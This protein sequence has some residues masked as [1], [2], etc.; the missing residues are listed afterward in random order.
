MDNEF[1][2]FMKF[3][4]QNINLTSPAIEKGYWT[5]DKLKNVSVGDENQDIIFHAVGMALSQWETLENEM[6]RLYLVFCSSDNAITSTAL[7]RA[8]GTIESSD[9][10]R[11][12]L[13]EAARVYFGDHN[14]PCGI[15]KPY[16]LLFESHKK[17]SERRN[18]IAHGVVRCFWINNENKGNFLLPASYNTGRNSTFMDSLNEDNGG[19][20]MTEYYRYTSREIYAIA[21]KFA[22]LNAFILNCVI[23]AGKV[24]GHLKIELAH[25]TQKTIEK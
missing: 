19:P 14:Y 8:F 17:A 9:G 3:E 2:R 5:R 25:L 12:A 6:F 1:E 10:R 20:F 4:A 23:A 7:R 11:K 22:E 16:K 21:Q 13:E 24:E 15:A 18:E